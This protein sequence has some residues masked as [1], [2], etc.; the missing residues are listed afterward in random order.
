MV[1][2]VAVSDRR[3]RGVEVGDVVSRQRDA[4]GAGVLFEPFAVPR[5]GDRGDVLVLG[6][7]PG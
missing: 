5:A 4:G 7:Q 1:V 2:V 6:Q 3:R